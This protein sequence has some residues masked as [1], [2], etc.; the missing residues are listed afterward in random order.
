MTNLE[1]IFGAS[2]G[3]DMVDLDIRFFPNASNPRWILESRFKRPWHLKTWPRTSLRARL[4]YRAVWAA[5]FLGLRMQSSRAVVKADPASIY[6]KLREDNDVLSVFVGTPGPNRKFVIFAQNATRSCF[7]KVPAEPSSFDLVAREAAALD[8]LSTDPDIQPLIPGHRMIDG[9]LAVDSV[10]GAGVSFRPISNA[11]ILRVSRLLERRSE[12]AEPL[13]AVRR[14]FDT[15]HEGE[16]VRADAALQSRL[17]RLRT[18]A[19]HFWDQLDPNEPVVLYNAH[20][21]FTQWNVLSAADGGARIIDWEMYGPKPRYF[22]LIHYHVSHCILVRH[23][24]AAEVLAELSSI[25][26]ETGDSETWW[27]Y[28]G[29]YFAVQSLFYASVYERQEVLHEENFNQ[30]NIWTKVLETLNG[31]DGMIAA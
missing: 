8:E 3:S 27:R 2:E 28:V 26:T 12:F 17:A 30:I 24:G 6:M 5:S 11:E 23:L 4:I 18:A 15:E 14:R 13:E 9:H 10:E 22:D 16:P 7:V 31:N 25:Q 19:R 20:G 21:D 29:H 1:P